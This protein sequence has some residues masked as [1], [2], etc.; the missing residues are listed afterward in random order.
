MH[1]YIIYNAIS[2]HV[3]NSGYAM[4]TYVRKINIQDPMGVKQLAIKYIFNH[5]HY[6]LVL[7]L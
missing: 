3:S 7:L 2:K 5:K 6:H 1:V 4:K